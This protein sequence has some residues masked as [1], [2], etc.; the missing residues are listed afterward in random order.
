MV[1]IS[2]DIGQQ[3]PWERPRYPL[4]VASVE[5]SFDATPL[6]GLLPLVEETKKRDRDNVVKDEAV[7]TQ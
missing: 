2:D 4:Q 5:A 1:G 7:S 6:L 3:I